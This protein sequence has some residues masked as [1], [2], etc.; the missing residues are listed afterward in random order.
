MK[1]QIKGLVAASCSLGIALL[2]SGPAWSQAEQAP[3]GAK[4]PATT[5]S[6]TLE[7]L[8]TIVVH[9]RR[10]EDRLFESEQDFYRRYNE[11]NARD[12]LDVSCNVWLADPNFRGAGTAPE[13]RYCLPKFLAN[14][15]AL[16]SPRVPVTS[17]SGRGSFGRGAI[18]GIPLGG[19]ASMVSNPDGSGWQYSYTTYW[20]NSG[21]ISSSGMSSQRMSE[22]SYLLYLSRRAELQANINKVMQNDP[23]L[24]VF[25]DRFQALVDERDETRRVAAEARK[26]RVALRLEQ[27]KCPQ[28]SS[29]RNLTKACKND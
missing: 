17:R 12:D 18:N 29:P 1:M 4:P 3:A 19:G 23:Q 7:E 16:E 13:K 9:A 21:N 5:D 11:L 27:R 8:D 20:S 14:R 25:A 15:I 28:P 22:Q 26:L 24:Q 6:M 10:F 2:L